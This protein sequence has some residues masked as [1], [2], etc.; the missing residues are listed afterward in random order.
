[1]GWRPFVSVGPELSNVWLGLKVIKGGL[2][3]D[4]LKLPGTPGRRGRESH[5]LI[6]GLMKTATRQHAG[7][8][9]A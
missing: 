4:R 8:Q 1:M 6:F 2:R 3:S 5:R 9:K 7:L